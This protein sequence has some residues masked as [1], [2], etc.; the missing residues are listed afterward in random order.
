MR[1]SLEQKFF[2]IREQEQRKALAD[3]TLQKMRE[4]APQG[5]AT[6]EQMLELIPP[7]QIES[8]EEHNATVKWFF[9]RG[10]I[11]GLKGYI[12]SREQR[13][14]ETARTDQLT[15]LRNRRAF[16]EQA[17]ILFNQAKG[18]SPLEHEMR[19]QIDF[20]IIFLDI[21]FFKKINDAFGHEAGDE[22]LK[23]VAGVLQKCSRK[24]DLVCRYGG[25]EFV[26]ASLGAKP[27]ARFTMAERM[28]R[29]LEE[30]EF[31]HNGVRIPLTASFGAAKY[32][33]GE[34]LEQLVARADGFMYKAKQP[35]PQSGHPGRNRVV[36]A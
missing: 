14:H 19:Q 2:E 8:D 13:L 6:P 30:T 3:A 21:D 25:E 7:D 10:D 24:S 28:R 22:A 31:F 34:T 11:E 29:T 5:V 4:L 18:T 20:S 15:G 36:I 16:D 27:G 26:V 35:D 17:P 33:P 32:E 9:E 12:R 23:V 1:E